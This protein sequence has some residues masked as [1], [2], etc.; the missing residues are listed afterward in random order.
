MLDTHQL[1][2]RCIQFLCKSTNDI[3]PALNKE[4]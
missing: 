3:E 4:R 2:I 1:K